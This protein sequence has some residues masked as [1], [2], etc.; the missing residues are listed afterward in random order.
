MR[1][2]IVGQIEELQ[3]IN[4]SIQEKKELITKF[5][6]AQ[7]EHDQKLKDSIALYAKV[8]QAREAESAKEIALKNTQ[9]QTESEDSDSELEEL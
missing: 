3:K 8:K 6:I 5:A 4:S 9:K 2:N 7:S 1:Q